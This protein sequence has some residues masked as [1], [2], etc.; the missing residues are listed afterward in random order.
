MSAVLPRSAVEPHERYN[1][2][3]LFATPDEWRDACKRLLARFPEADAYRGHLAEGADTLLKWLNLSED[4]WLALGK[5]F[6]YALMEQSVD[7]TD[8]AAN[9]MSDQVYGLMGRWQAANA[10]TNPEVLH[11]GQE[12]LTQ[13]M[14]REPRLRTY[15]QY[16][17]DLF[18]MQ[19]HVRSAEIEEL[20][21]MISEPFSAM[22][23]I[24]DTLV[25]ADL[26][27]KPA[28]GGDGTEKTL[29]HGTHDILLYDTDREIRRTTWENYA[30][31]YLSVNNALAAGLSG[32]M[33]RDVFTMRAR[34]FDTVLDMQLYEH[35]LPTA[36]FHNLIETYKKHIPTWHRYWRARK[37]ALGVDVLH[38]YDIWAPLTQHSPQI[39]FK[40]AVEM[41]CDG[42]TPLG[43][44]YVEL[45]RR[46][47]LEQRWVDYVPN[48][49]KVQ[50][51][52][53]FGWQ[54]THPFI[55][56]SFNGDLRSMSTLAHEL[57]HSMHSYYTWQNQPFAY[58]HYSMFVAETASN[59]N[60][61]MVRAHLLKT[62][63]DRDFQLALIDETMNNI[64]RYFFIM[65]TLARFELEVHTMVEQG[66]GVTAD[67]LNQLMA[68]LFAEGY[69]EEMHIDRD[70]VGITW[71]QFSHLYV[72]YYTFQYATGISA[73]HALAARILNGEAGAADKYIQF[74][75]AGSSVY[76]MDALKLAGVDMTTPQAVE[77]TF[78]VLTQV[79]DRLE[80]LF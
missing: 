58:S 50:G 7:K 64:H 6:V 70:R 39:D 17:D 78:G 22:E 76:P 20:L 52:F 14:Q 15:Q 32:A 69:G 67:S 62:T 61:A 43:Q 35:N 42:M 33:K 71:A 27:F 74:L 3:S 5:V 34:R 38:P 2:E 18:R 56:M 21:G 48:Q 25:N 29:T 23:N 44:E 19:T 75:S 47:C 9:A 63:T 55:M 46:G 60:Q 73:A 40:Q 54:G 8:Q 28:L 66:E 59:F 30:D 1:R 77:E 80:S 51:A 79:V 65:P 16:V 37:K 26:K 53:S 72:P 45:V 4:I 24:P 68:N 12:T 11:I 49:G 57:G 31:G 13:W 36:V 41:I 10:F